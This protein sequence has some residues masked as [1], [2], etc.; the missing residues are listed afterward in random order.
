V[1]QR[2]ERVFGRERGG[3]AVT[4]HTR[5]GSFGASVLHGNPSDRVCCVPHRRCDT[6]GKFEAVPSGIRPRQFAAFTCCSWRSGRRE[7]RSSPV[8]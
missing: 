4:D 6:G 3:T 5:K 7:P 1:A 2:G 8:S